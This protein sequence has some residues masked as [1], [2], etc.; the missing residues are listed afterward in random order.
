MKHHFCKNVLLI[1]FVMDE[2]TLKAKDILLFGVLVVV[3]YEIW[4]FTSRC[5]KK[6]WL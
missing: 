5:L 1:R 4:R 2:V 6:V 3:A